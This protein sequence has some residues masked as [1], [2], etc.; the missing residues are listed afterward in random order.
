MKRK[1][2][3]N[4]VT[5]GRGT[6]P[7]VILICTL[8]WILTYFLSPL[9]N[10]SP[11]EATTPTLWQLLPVSQWPLWA[12][13]L[14]SYLIYGVI[15]YFL[16]ELNNRY[17][18][19]R[20]RASVQTAVYF[21]F[22]TVCTEMHRLCAGCVSALLFAIS[23]YV[24]FG[25]YQRTQ[26]SGS[27]FG[28]FAFLGAGSLLF[29]PLTF[30]SIPFLIG[31]Y[32]FQSLTW[33]SFFAALLGW[34]FPYWFLLGHAF[35]YSEMELFYTPFRQL[36]TFCLPFDFS[37]LQPWQ[38]ATL[39]YLLLLYLVSSIHCISSGF[40]D[41]IRTRAYLQFLILL[42]GF[43]FLLLIVQPIF[44]NDLLPLLM[45]TVSILAGHYFILTHSKASNVFFIVSVSLLVLLFVF[46]TWM[47]L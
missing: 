8:C 29:P 41:K 37:L 1:S 27:L 24:L 45:I 13:Q 17:A 11:T 20:I 47:L 38:L 6:L 18:I 44:C 25:S 32:R 42:T 22:A 36:T 26:A 4:Q 19:I 35:F 40:E 46:N 3:Q 15:G 9:R 30:L 43:L 28:S 5:A 16:I 33:R 2:F 7:A 10:V 14:S 12:E 21:L 39:G 31:A 34:C 23:I